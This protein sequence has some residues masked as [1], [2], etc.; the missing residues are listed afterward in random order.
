M[1]EELDTLLQQPVVLHGLVQECRVAAAGAVVGGHCNVRGAC[2]D[3]EVR[4][5]D[6]ADSKAMEAHNVE[7][8]L[9]HNCRHNGS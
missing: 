7:G 9:V 1:L 6:V 2:H 4:Y 3:R 5:N 8:D